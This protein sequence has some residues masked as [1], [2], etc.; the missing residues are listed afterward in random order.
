MNAMRM[1]VW[2]IMRSDKR[3]LCNWLGI[4]NH[5]SQQTGGSG[6]TKTR[7]PPLYPEGSAGSDS[8]RTK[9]IF[10]YQA[11]SNHVSISQHTMDWVRDYPNV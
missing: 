1:Y 4:Y 11:M 2:I 6:G 3:F 5:S 10:P 7:V 9:E 8:Q